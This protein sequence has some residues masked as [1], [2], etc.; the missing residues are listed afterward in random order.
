MDPQP[1][2]RH[3][4]RQANSSLNRPPFRP[5]RKNWGAGL[6]QE[7]LGVYVPFFGCDALLAC[8]LLEGFAQLIEVER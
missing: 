1:S 6:L 7:K 4:S 5:E 8:Q 2:M 3:T